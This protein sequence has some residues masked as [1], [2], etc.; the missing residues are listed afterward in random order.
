MKPHLWQMLMTSAVA[1]KAKAELTLNLLSES[2]AGIG[3]HSTDD[4]YRNAESALLMLVDALDRIKL[5]NKINTGQD[6]IIG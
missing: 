5:L 6:L 1:D 2:P 3:D 4:F